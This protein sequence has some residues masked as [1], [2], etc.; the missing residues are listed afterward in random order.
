MTQVLNAKGR[1]FSCSISAIQDY[2]SCPAKYAARRFYYTTPYQQNEFT[3]WG[4]RVHT[5]GELF[6]KG[7][8]PNDPEALKPVEPYATAMLRSGHRI[9]PEL[10]I[11]LNRNFKPTQWFSK[12]TW[13]RCKIDVVITK[14]KTTAALFDW[15]TGKI[16]EDEDQLR[17][18]AAM[19][20]KIRPQYENFEGKYIWLKH[21]QPTSIKPLAKN[22]ISEV[23]A[24]FLPRIARMEEAWKHELF[25]PRPSGL[26]PWCAVDNCPKR[27]G[28]R[29][30]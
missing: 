29:K 27:R 9:E 6:L 12:E 26:C 13:I 15:K 28:V 16:K 30:V 24:D 4:N 25:D 22:D 10:E 3:I 8:N 11:A 21:K 14:Q 1:P 7:I 20:S 5:A 17:L 18:S 23:W 19:L 2:E